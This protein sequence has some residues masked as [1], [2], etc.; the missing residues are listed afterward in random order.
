MRVSL[1]LRVF[2]HYLPA[3]LLWAALIEGLLLLLVLWEGWC[4]CRVVVQRCP[5]AQE[6]A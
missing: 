5:V 2:R 3:G 4:H 6:G 1:M